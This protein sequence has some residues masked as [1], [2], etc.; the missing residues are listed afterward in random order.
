MLRAAT[1]RGSPKGQNAA[2]AG[3]ISTVAF[4]AGGALLAG[5]AVL[6]LTGGPAKPKDSIVVGPSADNGGAGVW[7][8][9]T[10]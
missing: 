6:F 1:R 8:R 5:G 9:G 4:V 2:T 3:T 10:F 7:M